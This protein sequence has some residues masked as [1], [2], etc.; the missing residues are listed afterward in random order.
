MAVDKKQGKT[1]NRA[2]ATSKINT[3]RENICTNPLAIFLRIGAQNKEVGLFLIHLTHI[4]KRLMLRQHY[5][6]N[7]K[8]R[9]SKITIT[10]IVKDKKS[11][12]FRSRT[13]M[14]QLSQ[15][16][17]ECVD[18]RHVLQELSVRKQVLFS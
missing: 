15:S 12:F 9:Q 11:M 4:L 18:L 13:W 6:K 10:F 8:N 16:D 7:E 17:N 5:T 1:A 3:T 14:L 2:E